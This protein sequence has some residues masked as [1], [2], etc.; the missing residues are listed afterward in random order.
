MNQEKFSK[1]YTSF[2]TFCSQ[3][4]GHLDCPVEL[5]AAISSEPDD[6]EY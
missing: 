6:P 5:L 4:E 1:I 3:K 2:K